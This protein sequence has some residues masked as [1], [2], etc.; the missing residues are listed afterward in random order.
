M[1]ERKSN[2]RHDANS[3]NY[4]ENHYGND[5]N[6]KTYSNMAYKAH[7]WNGWSEKM[8]STGANK[9]VYWSPEDGCWYNRKKVGPNVVMV[10]MDAQVDPAWDGIHLTALANPNLIGDPVTLRIA[11]VGDGPVVVGRPMEFSVYNSR[12][13]VMV[14]FGSSRSAR[15]PAPTYWRGGGDLLTRTGSVTFNTPGAQTFYVSN[16]TNTATLNV[17]VLSLGFTI[18]GTN[19]GTPLTTNAGQNINLTVTAMNGNAVNAGYRGTV[20]FTSTDDAAVLPADYQFQAGDNGVRVFNGVQL[21]K[22]YG[23]DPTQTI[24]VTDG[25]GGNFGSITYTI[26]PGAATGIFISLRRPDSDFTESVQGTG[27]P[28]SLRVGAIDA[29][30][31]IATSYRGTVGFTSNDNVAGV[32][33]PGNYAFQAGDNGSKVFNFTLRTVREDT[34]TITVTDAANG[35]FTDTSDTISVRGVATSFVCSHVNPVF[36]GSLFSISVRARD[37]NNRTAVRYGGLVNVSKTNPNLED[38]FPTQLQFDPAIG[39]PLLRGVFTFELRL[40][41]QGT[42]TFRDNANNAITGTDVVDFTV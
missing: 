11:R 32:V 41:S 18:T 19:N 20:H 40:F 31:N 29:N 17:T 2:G 14:I 39:I 38:N 26:V 35:A 15:L 25:A 23:S 21:K 37:V 42:F 8:W 7:Y 4:T 27:Y 28:F 36:Q 13:E 33:L 34:T 30:N 22:I 16:G 10:P 5:V 1:T 24:T 6:G 12:G 3:S 9:W